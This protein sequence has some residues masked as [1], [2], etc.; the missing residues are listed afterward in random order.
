MIVFIYICRSILLRLASLGVLIGSLYRLL[1]I[2]ADPDAG[3]CGNRL[4]DK[5]VS[6]ARGSIKVTLAVSYMI[7][8]IEI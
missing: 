8:F 2:N 7:T 1:I 5:T 4:W 3:L 6:T